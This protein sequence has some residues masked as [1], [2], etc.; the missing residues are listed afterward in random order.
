M[1]SGSIKTV[2]R[3]G[4]RGSC[5]AQ[6]VHNADRLDPDPVCEP[7]SNALVLAITGPAAQLGGDLADLAYARG[8]N[9]VSVKVARGSV[10]TRARELLQPAADHSIGRHPC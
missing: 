1:G 5:C 10:L 7:G 3:S 6:D 8:P 4:C 9:G 2:G